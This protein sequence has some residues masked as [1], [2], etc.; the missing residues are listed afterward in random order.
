MSN[1]HIAWNSQTN[2]YV[3]T[4]VQIQTLPVLE[5]QTLTVTTQQQVI[6]Q[7]AEVKKK[8]TNA[9]L[10]LPTAI[11][12]KICLLIPF[13]FTKISSRIRK[14]FVVTNEFQQILHTVFSKFAD[15]FD[16]FDFPT[17]TE[18]VK[19]PL[20][21]CYNTSLCSYDKF[22][23]QMSNRSASCLTIA[24]GKHNSIDIGF[25]IRRNFL[26]EWTKN[27]LMTTYVCRLFALAIAFSG[28]ML[29]DLK[30]PGSLDLEQNRILANG[31]LAQRVKYQE[32][33]LSSSALECRADNI[34][35]L[36]LW[37]QP[38]MAWVI[39]DANKQQLKPAHLDVIL[40]H[41]H[42]RQLKVNGC[43]LDD[44]H[45]KMIADWLHTYETEFMCIE[46]KNNKF[47]LIG[48]EMILQAYRNR[49]VSTTLRLF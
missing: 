22:M 13:D 16:F 2:Q 49:K 18:L 27:E 23:M 44:E 41:A 8:E 15:C 20:L 4:I 28:I 33:R 38:Q 42:L 39:V 47:T 11:L 5:Y 34:E 45:A 9:L 3:M 40:S 14:E 21:P 6:A 17:I 48:T 46:C 24:S 26:L 36:K 32:Q 43:L 31:M 30:V 19:T 1:Y 37:Y 35:I 7:E 10:D 25:I 12:Q 29:N